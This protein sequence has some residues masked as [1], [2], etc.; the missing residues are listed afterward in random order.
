M[1]LQH[2]SAHIQGW[3]HADKEPALSVTERG[4]CRAI[5]WYWII[6]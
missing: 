4:Y 6:T 2:V 3:V 1:Y 5:G